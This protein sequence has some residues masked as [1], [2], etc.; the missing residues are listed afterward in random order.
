MENTYYNL[1]EAIENV[2]E[3]LRRN[4]LI[5]GNNIIIENTGS[6]FKISSLAGAAGA[7]R[8]KGYFKVI[9]TGS[10][11]EPEVTVVDGGYVKNAACGYVTAKYGTSYIRYPVDSNSF[12]I[13]GACS[14]YL[15]IDLLT[16]T[17]EVK[18]AEPAMPSAPAGKW[19]VLL[20]DIDLDESDNPRI[21]QIH[22]TGEVYIDVFRDVYNGPFAIRDTGDGETKQITVCNGANPSDPVAGYIWHGNLVFPV[23]P[24]TFPVNENG[25]DLFLFLRY[26][27]GAYSCGIV[28]RD[29]LIT[30]DYQYAST[31]IGYVRQS[32]DF[33]PIY[34]YLKN[35]WITTG[36]VV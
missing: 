13:S 23:A 17:A 25:P 22:K 15:E 14:I 27:G 36:R 11:P 24:A 5:A 21:N 35:N 18:Q 2:E 3:Q 32:G 12:E 4:R 19:L 9:S 29:E 6:G 7:F 30:D 8:Y 10:R 26:S 20:A 34:Q 33:V 16:F 28:T 1:T 31:E